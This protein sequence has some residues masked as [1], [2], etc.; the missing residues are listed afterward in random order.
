MM[1]NISAVAQLIRFSLHRNDLQL[2]AHGIMDNA[3]DQEPEDQTQIWFYS[4][5]CAQI[6]QNTY[7]FYAVFLHSKLT[8]LIR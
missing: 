4:R 5:L 7:S 8:G 1:Q 3:P 2:S 6:G